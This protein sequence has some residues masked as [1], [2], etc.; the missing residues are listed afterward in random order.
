M[1]GEVTM[2]PQPEQEKMV[3]SAWIFDVD[4]VITDPEIKQANPLL[5]TEIVKKINAQEPVALVTGRALKWVLERVVSKI[6]SQI[7][8][9]M[10]LNNLFVSGEFGGGHIVYENG[11]RKEAINSDFSVP[12]EIIEETK[13]LTEHEFSDSM[14]IDPDKKTMLSIEMND[15]LTVAAFNPRQEELLPKLKE[16]LEMHPKKTEFEI[17]E[18]RIATNIKNK[19]ANKSYATQQVI[20]WLSKRGIKPKQFFAFGDASS[21]AE[22]PQEISR[23]NLPVSFVFVGEKWQLENIS[24][25]FP[26]IFTQNKF[27]NGTLEFLKS[28]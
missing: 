17:H 3:N 16:I 7:D 8:N 25:P 27:D 24:I 4:G 20:S 13:Q 1:V 22:I 21:D 23:N 15:G 11:V 19:K 28:L 18:D 2:K 5:I 9:P 6:E 26:T 14:F 12:K 10:L